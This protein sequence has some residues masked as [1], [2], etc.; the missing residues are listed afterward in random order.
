MLRKEEGSVLLFS[1][2]ILF[3]LVVITT[4]IGLVVVNRANVVKASADKNSLLAMSEQHL[5][6]SEN[7]L[8]ESIFQNDELARYYM[9]MKY[10]NSDNTSFNTSVVFGGHPELDSYLRTLIEPAFQSSVKSNYTEL[11]HEDVLETMFAYITLR[12]SVINAPG[13]TTPLANTPQVLV[14]SQSADGKYKVNNADIVLKTDYREG[15][16]SDLRNPTDYSTLYNYVSTREPIL[17]I[18]YKGI[19]DTD[20]DSKNLASITGDIEINIYPIQYSVVGI[21]ITVP[22]FEEISQDYI[23]VREHRVTQIGK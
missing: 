2:A 16:S 13:A 22:S 6:S 20:A 15:G 21:T 23:K 7:A 12:R 9:G 19:H 5:I 1:I 18:K 17:K 4:T 8:S 14:N 11:K 10:F 3:M